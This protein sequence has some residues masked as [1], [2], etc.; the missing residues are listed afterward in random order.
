MKLTERYNHYRDRLGENDEFIWE[1]IKKN[2]EVCAQAT[3]VELAEACHVS[4]TTILR[5]AKKLGYEGFSEMK[6][7]LR[8]ELPGERERLSNI[9]EV[10]GLYNEVIRRLYDRDCRDVFRLIDGARNLYVYSSG[11]AQSTVARE[12]MRIFMNT[13]KLFFEIKGGMETGHLLATINAEDVV[14]MVSYT[15]EGPETVSFARDLKLRGVPIVSITT[16]ADNTLAGLSDINL[17]IASLTLGERDQE[18][19]YTSLTTF[20]ILV[21]ILFLKYREYREGGSTDES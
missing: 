2:R 11:M 8:A 6:I 19:E 1:Y 13:G 14:F 15:G 4:R 10:V 5:F 3:I 7:S 9:N 16:L 18:L 12:M 21:E 17:Y 20:Y